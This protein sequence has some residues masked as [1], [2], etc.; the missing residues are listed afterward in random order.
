MA[1]PKHRS[2]LARMYD[3]DLMSVHATCKA[4]FVPLDLDLRHALI[5]RAA[6]QAKV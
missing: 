1:G 4:S 3:D 6:D 2:S 5:D